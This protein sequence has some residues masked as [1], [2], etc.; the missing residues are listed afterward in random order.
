MNKNF[1]QA[2]KE[3]AQNEVPDLWDRIEAGLKEKS[4]PAKKD[5]QEEKY[6]QKMEEYKVQSP[7][8]SGI[9]PVIKILKRYSALAA[10][11]VCAAVVIPAAL[12]LGRNGNLSGSN[13][14]AI[15]EENMAAAEEKSEA[16]RKMAVAGETAGTGADAAA[17]EE[18]LETEEGAILEETVETAEEAAPEESME[19]AEEAAPEEVVGEAEKAVENAEEGAAGTTEDTARSTAGLKEEMKQSSKEEK[20]SAQGTVFTHVVIEVK[21]TAKGKTVQDG[22]WYHVTVKEDPSGYLKAEEQI[23]VFVPAYSSIAFV[24]GKTFEVDMTYEKEEG[25]FIC[26]DQVP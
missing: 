24:Q 10:A 16:G 21:D 15:P 6:T 14:E 3:L 12:F 7:V 4:A 9:R 23:T 11:A 18:T 8:K 26:T 25:Y 19:T 22:S 1:E 17:P 13:W 5:I 2:Y 20:E